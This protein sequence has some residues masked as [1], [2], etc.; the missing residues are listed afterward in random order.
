[1][2]GILAGEFA[3][4]ARPRMEALIAAGRRHEAAR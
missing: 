3:A 2:L 1:V 4:K